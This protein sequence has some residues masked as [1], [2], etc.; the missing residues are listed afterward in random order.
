M[1]KKN[2][3]ISLL[4]IIACFAVVALHTQRNMKL[5]IVNNEILYYFSRFAIPIFFMVNGYLISI[6]KRTNNYYLKKIM[7]FGL[8]ILLWSCLFGIIKFTNPISIFIKSI[9]SKGPLAIFW[10]FWALI[11]IYIFIIIFNNVI[12]KNKNILFFIFLFISLSID[13]I[14]LIILFKKHFFIQSY[15]P[16][17]FR[18]WTWLTYFYLGNLIKSKNC[19]LSYSKSKK[20]LSIIV[21][22]ILS[23][24]SVLFQHYLFMIF[25]NII[26]SEYIY[27]N[28]IIFLWSSS[29]F[30]MVF[31]LNINNSK[32][33]SVINFIE[34]K[35]IGIYIMHI[36]ILK[37]HDF[38]SNANGPLY[39][40]S[41]WVIIISLSIII[42]YI[43]SLNKYTKK[44]VSI[45]N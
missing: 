32:L 36:L 27:C 31:N 10:F 9:F 15:I 44:L 8:F 13:F 7:N 45:G 2:I 26:N 4:K 18:L 30:L 23:I 43:L 41:V 37:I 21:F 5:H 19:L 1:N 17:T 22:L 14:Q 28:L 42:T 40:I 29:L 3:S 39:S 12:E 38:T 33:I 20:I 6:K 35:I 25:T 16:Q 24:I 11:L 34:D